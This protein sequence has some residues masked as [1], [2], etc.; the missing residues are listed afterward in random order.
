[1]RTQALAYVNSTGGHS[2]D[3]QAVRQEVADNPK[4][5]FQLHDTSAGIF[6][7]CARRRSNPQ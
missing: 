2:Y 1:M 7:R 4:R 5:R 6:I 3:A